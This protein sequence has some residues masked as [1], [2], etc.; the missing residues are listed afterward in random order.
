M[1]IV[2]VTGGLGTG[3]STVAELLGR[4]GALVMDADHMA[5]EVMAPRRAAWRKIRAAFGARVLQADGAVDR[6]ALARRVFRSPRARRALER[7]VHPAVFRE[8]RRR[9]RQARLA[10]R[11][12]VA[13]VELPLLVEAGAERLVDIVVVVT[14]PDRIRRRRLQQ[15]GMPREEIARRTAAQLALSAKVALADYVVDNSD[16]MAQTRRQVRQLWT[17]LQARKGRRRD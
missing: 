2:G 9:L 3:K 8:I 4:Q 14:A 10:G 1:I 13:V 11:V 5:H 15:R 12:R 6:A 7:I 16:G 17:R